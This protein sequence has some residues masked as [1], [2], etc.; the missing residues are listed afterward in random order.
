MWNISSMLE[1]MFHMH[2]SKA[3]YSPRLNF[4]LRLQ[5]NQCNCFT[6]TKWKHG[7]RSTLLKIHI[8]YF[9]Q[10][11]STCWTLAICYFFSPCFYHQYLLSII[12]CRPISFCCPQLQCTVTSAIIPVI[13]FMHLSPSLLITLM[14]PLNL[15]SLLSYFHNIV[16]N[17]PP[18]QHL[19]MTSFL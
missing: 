9:M 14:Y 10:S 11:G 19:L 18:L 7:F 2:F 1:D 17:T 13:L 8:K 15:T 3:S 5:F 12:S 6:L 16:S 4:R